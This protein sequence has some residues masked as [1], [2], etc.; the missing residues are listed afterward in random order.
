MET[1]LLSLPAILGIV[2]FVIYYILKK[3]VTEDPIIKSIIDKLK[4]EEPDFENRWTGLTPQQKEA[5]LKEDNN[6]RRKISSKD[7]Q[8][9]DKALTNQFRTNIFVYALCGILLA[10]GI[11]LFVKPK[12]LFID[13]IQIQNADSSSHE[14]I[15]DIDP[16]AVTWTSSGQNAEISA[17]LENIDTGKQTKRLNG[18]AS[19]GKIKFEAD[20]Y[21]NYDKILSNRNPNGANRLRAVL[22][23]GNEAFKSREFEIKVGVKII[24]YPDGKNNIIFNA[25]IDQRIVDNFH[26][27]PILT[28][29]KDAYFNGS[30]TFEANEYSSRPKISIGNPT[31]YTTTNLAF[32][33]NPREIINQNLYRTDIGSIR[34]AIKELKKNN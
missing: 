10:L 9:L 30:T 27:A 7:R 33:V 17:V 15:V 28:L 23:S 4:F 31:Q 18:R 14:Q 25:I 6:F 5:I 11:Y 3:S 24:C 29:F 32:N 13:S 1:F 34:E 12:P 21:T 16:I 20:A 19:D 8:I 26:F 2:G 22:Y